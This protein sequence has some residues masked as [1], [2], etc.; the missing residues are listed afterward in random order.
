MP[1]RCSRLTLYWL[2]DKECFLGEDECVRAASR[3]KSLLGALTEGTLSLA[4]EHLFFD[5]GGPNIVIFPLSNVSDAGVLLSDAHISVTFTC[6]NALQREVLTPPSSKHSVPGVCKPYP[7]KETWAFQLPRTSEWVA[8]SLRS[9]FTRHRIDDILS[10][11]EVT[12]Q[13]ASSVVSFCA[14]RQVPMREQRGVLYIGDDDLVFEPLFPLPAHDVVRLERRQCRHT[15]ARWIIFEAVGLDVYTSESPE[16]TPSLSLIFNNSRERD[17][18]AHLLAER[19]RVPRYHVSIQAISEA[20]RNHS[21]SSYEYLLHL[22]KWASRC[23]NDVFQYPIFP[24]V[25]ADYTSSKLDTSQPS[26]FRDLRKPIGALSP[27][28]LSLLRQRAQFLREAEE[29]TYLYSTHY[30][31]AAIVAYYLVRPHP[32]FQLSLQGGT[33][34]VP[35]R[36]LESIPQLWNSVTTNSSNFRELIPQFFNEGFM[37]LC[38][39]PLLPLGFR[40]DGAPV[41][42]YVKLPPW[43]AS[44]EDF[45]RQHRAALESDIVS[46]SLHFWIDLVFG[47]AQTGERA[48]EADN[49]FH[50]F[51]YPKCDRLLSVPG[52]HL[53]SREY[54]KEFGNVPIQLFANLH[55]PRAKLAHTL[56]CTAEALEACGCASNTADQQR[57]F[58]MMEELQFIEDATDNIADSAEVD[59]E[60]AHGLP[61]HAAAFTVISNTSLSCRSARFVTLGHNSVDP[62]GSSTAAL[63]VVGSDQ[64]TA[65]LFDVATGKRI[66]SFPDFDGLITAT[67]FHDGH[68]FVFTESK[69]CYVLSL[70]S[71]AV[72]H[73]MSD[74]TPAPVLHACFASQ[75]VVLAD[76]NAQLSGWAL[77]PSTSPLFFESP[78]PFTCEASSRVSCISSSA[79][80]DTIAAATEHLEVFVCRGD[81]FYECMLRHVPASS[82][83]LHI[84]PADRFTRFWVFFLE[85]AALYDL[86]G[87]PLRR[88]A[89]TPASIVTCPRLAYQ[90]YPVCVNMGSEPIKV[91]QLLHT[92]ERSVSLQS[93]H[94]RSLKLSSAGN[95]VAFVGTAA[96]N[97]EL[98]LVL[99]MVALT[100]E[101]PC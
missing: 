87:L 63:L 49:L 35:E 46:E 67:A 39:P 79:D 28:R 93:D 3:W 51:S 99:T 97:C 81:T 95:L 50:P 96:V 4:T 90:F 27:S 38:G 37:T 32:E 5:D 73:F 44:S 52:L 1:H 58:R 68:M 48:C 31:S 24:W 41:A 13:S 25:L 36:I 78:P 84:I 11:R 14:R 19:L 9:L 15:F 53:S 101:L 8:E 98:S 66:R 30:S 94:L 55:P 6:K 29:T 10:R 21:I 69:S 62:P 88:I 42:A 43:A 86:R 64:R 20:W 56:V 72:A 40:A 45:V 100:A 12:L 91:F 74:V 2:T 47:A 92:G 85:E 22:N 18:A 65:T 33:L 23:A 61:T 76:S 89:I 16:A 75:L 83:L 70:S 54:A 26:T 77:Q 57:I 71:N 34:D 17:E 60:G 7:N 82:T 59:S 80:D